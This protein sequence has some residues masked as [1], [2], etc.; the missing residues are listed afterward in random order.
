MAFLCED[1]DPGE[2]GGIALQKDVCRAVRSVT[3]KN[4]A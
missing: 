4:V 2:F 3:A 1:C